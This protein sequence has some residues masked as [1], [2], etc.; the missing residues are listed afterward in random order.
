MGHVESIPLRKNGGRPDCFSGS[1]WVARVMQDE[2]KKEMTRTKLIRQ[3]LW[4]P[5]V[6]H[7]PLFCH[8]P[9]EGFPEKKPELRDLRRM[10]IRISALSS[11]M[12]IFYFLKDKFRSQT[13]WFYNFFLLTCL[14]LALV[15]R[16]MAGLRIYFIFLHGYAISW[17]LSCL[18]PF[19]PT[20][21][22]LRREKQFCL[23]WNQ[24][25]VL[26]LHKQQL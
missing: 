20:S 26:L 8:S 19:I 25:Q 5:S 16:Y 10:A 6:W 4:M 22:Y 15:C 18:D 13:F 7:Q 1:K 17:T 11:F 23:S 14:A 9:K 2:T 24:T 21:L 12:V 3:H